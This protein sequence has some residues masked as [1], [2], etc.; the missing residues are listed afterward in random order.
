MT[1]RVLPQV[2]ILYT[3]HEYLPICL[4]EGQMIRTERKGNELC[5]HASPRRC[6]ECYPGISTEQFFMREMF[7]KS[8]LE[9]VDLFLAPSRF[10]RQRYID[11]GLPAERIMFEELGRRPTARLAESTEERPRNRLGFF[12]QL[13]PFKGAE[14]LLEAMKIL[15]ERQPEVHLN[16]HG[17]YV[18]YFAETYGR[19]FL[20]LVEQ[21]SGNVTYAGAYEHSELPRLMRD[22]DWVVLPSRWWENSPLVVQE[23]FTHGRPVICSGIGGLAEKVQDGVNGLHFNVGDPGS[24]ASVIER[25]VT[26]PGLWERLRAGIPH[27]YTVDEHV[28]SLTRL[29]RELL[30]QRSDQAVATALAAP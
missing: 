8:H 30:E 7:I 22:V 28:E 20:E 21:M 24:L 5:T 1:R 15:A 23:A 4:R 17:A 2:P 14:T 27:V 19:E 16:L 13:T 25:A 11:W 10:L 6:N 29:Y 12:G 18:E 9:N 26:E 3:L